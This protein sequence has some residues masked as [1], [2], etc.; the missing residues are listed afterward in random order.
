[1]RKA[2][3]DREESGEGEDV[4]GRGFDM[5]IFYRLGEKKREPLGGRGKKILN[6]EKHYGG[7]NYLYKK[8]GTVW[9]KGRTAEQLDCAKT[10]RAAR[11]M[12]R[13]YKKKRTKRCLEKVPMG[14]ICGKT[15]RSK[16]EKKRSPF[17]LGVSRVDSIPGGPGSEGKK[18]GPLERD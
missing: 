16:R 7:R 2:G 9:R 17:F 8:K 5:P 3:V 11:R 18:G 14:K 10:H 1:V 4:R 13:F 15:L 6:K 12:V